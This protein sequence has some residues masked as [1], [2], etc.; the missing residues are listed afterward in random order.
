MGPLEET[1]PDSSRIDPGENKQ[2]I[3]FFQNLES[4]DFK[5]GPG[6]KPP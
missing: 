5:E 6:A 2:R 3:L 4:R 1:K